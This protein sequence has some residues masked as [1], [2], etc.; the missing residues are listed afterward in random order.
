MLGFS[1]RWAGSEGLRVGVQLQRPVLEARGANRLGVAFVSVCVCLPA[2]LP[3]CVCLPVCV[4]VCVRTR[5]WRWESLV[6]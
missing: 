1:Q 4:R 5:V 2:C 3:A 6:G